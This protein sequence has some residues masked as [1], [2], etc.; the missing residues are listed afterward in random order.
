MKYMGKPA[1]FIC[2]R[3]RMQREFLNSNN[4]FYSFS[5]VQRVFYKNDSKIIK[6]QEVY[7]QQEKIILFQNISPHIIC[8]IIVQLTF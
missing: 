8:G 7:L 5:E 2:I 4:N 6:N 3:S 1:S